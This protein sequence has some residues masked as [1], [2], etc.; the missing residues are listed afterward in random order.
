MWGW[1][2]RVWTPRAEIIC[3]YTRLQLNVTVRPFTQWPLSVDSRG[4]SSCALQ[5]TIPSKL[6][7]IQKKSPTRLQLLTPV[8]VARLYLPLVTQK[9]WVKMRDT[10]FPAAEGSYP[11]F[12]EQN[13]I[14]SVS[15]ICWL[16]AA[17]REPCCCG[18]CCLHFHKPA[19]ESCLRALLTT[20]CY[21]SSQEVDGHSMAQVQWQNLNPPPVPRPPL[22]LPRLWV[23]AWVFI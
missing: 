14:L 5:I 3:V 19:V 10:P 11:V 20:S 13:T 12:W 4:P 6:K 17:W 23:A 1:V 21:C 8:R 9:A 16:G 15:C 2:F 22:R 7:G 18:R